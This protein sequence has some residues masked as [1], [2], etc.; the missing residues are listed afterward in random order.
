MDTASL[1]EIQEIKIKIKE[2]KEGIAKRNALAKKREELENI[3]L[4]TQIKSQHSLLKAHQKKQQD[5]ELASKYYSQANE[6][7]KMSQ[8]LLKKLSL[9][10]KEIDKWEEAEEEDIL[11]LQN[12]LIH[13]ILKRY[14]DQNEI[15]EVI[16]QKEKE[17]KELNEKINGLIESLANIEHLITTIVITRK[18]IKNQ[19]ILSYIFGSSPNLMI[20]QCLQGIQAIVN[21]EQKTIAEIRPQHSNSNLN[22]LLDELQIY[23]EN[24][25][26]DCEKRWNYRHLDTLIEKNFL[27]AQEFKEKLESHQL[28]LLEDITKNSKELEDWLEK[29]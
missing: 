25:F 18:R 13:I 14:P 29:F 3:L 17:N 16:K 1:Q 11:Q 28:H 12:A 2:I 10:D 15:I 27:K 24:L 4:E 20:A 22:A 9:V 26:K 21:E 7:E 6:Y 19:G 8:D 5:T 23:A